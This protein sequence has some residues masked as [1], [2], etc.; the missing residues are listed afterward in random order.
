MDICVDRDKVS[1]VGPG[2]RF[3]TTASRTTA[4]GKS[5]SVGAFNYMW[6]FLG[7]NLLQAKCNGHLYPFIFSMCEELMLFPNALEGL[8]PQEQSFLPHTIRLHPR[9]LLQGQRHPSLRSCLA[10]L[11]PLLRA[12][13]LVNSAPSI[14]LCS[15]SS[16][17]GFVA[18]S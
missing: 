6:I 8:P 4:S 11:A 1:V 3:D 14:P 17:L 18:H 2:R 9:L 15:C 7:F 10:F 13:V 12:P 5:L 16:A